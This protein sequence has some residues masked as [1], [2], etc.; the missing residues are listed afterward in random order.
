ML[1]SLEGYASQRMERV[2][3]RAMQLTGQ[4][5]SE[6]EPPL[7]WSLAMAALTRGEWDPAPQ[8]R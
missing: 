3:A 2:H 8:V 5:G 4:L 7:V 6:P 1:L